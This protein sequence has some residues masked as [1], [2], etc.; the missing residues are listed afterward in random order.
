MSEP[1]STRTVADHDRIV[2]TISAA[3]TEVLDYDLPE[4]TDDSRLF[5]QLGLDST[6]V[7]EL[8]M[9]LEEAL[10]VEFDTDN[11]EMS[12]FETVR[13]LAGFVASELG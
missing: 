9:R 2:A 1:A 10:D 5:D 3:L 7:F 11:L 6:G 8:L 12:H 13:S 4:I